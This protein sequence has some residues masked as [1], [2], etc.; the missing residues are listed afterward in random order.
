MDIIIIVL[1]SINL[2]VGVIALILAL[3]KK[4]ASGDNSKLIDNQNKNRESLMVYVQKEFSE[5]KLSINKSF[6]DSKEN[7][8]SLTNEANK[9]NN[10]DMNEFKERIV[11]AINQDMEKINKKVEDRLELGF[12]KTNK[13]FN[14]VVERLAVIDKAQKDMQ[15][16]SSDVVSLNTILTDKKTRGTFG[17]INLYQILYNVFGENKKLYETQKQLSNGM[18]VDAMLHAPDPLGNIAVDSKFPLE[19]YQRMIDKALDQAAVKQAEKDF[20]SN[21]KKHIKDISDKYI[22]AGETASQAIMF[23]PAEAIFAE[24]NANHQDIIDYSYENKVW[25]A[26]PTTLVATLTIIQSVI[27]NVERNKYAKE[28]DDNL[29]LLYDEFRRYGLRWSK[30]K[31]SIDTVSKTAEE[32]HTTSKRIDSKFNKIYKF[33]KKDYLEELDEIEE[34]E[35]DNSDE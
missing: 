25:L 1:I 17:E 7:L 26:S 18:M 13:T 33:D 30:L 5:F 21:V 6:S 9:V 28:I 23:I 20:K 22:I 31:K 8:I 27:I 15:K 29:K 35:D 16:L 4:G 10:K 19:N 32:V 24:I 11:T 3:R 2:V 34:N 14:D 12:E